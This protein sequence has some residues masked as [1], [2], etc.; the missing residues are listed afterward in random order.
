MSM[1]HQF[2]LYFD[3]YKGFSRFESGSS[4]SQRFNT[5]EVITVGN[6]EEDKEQKHFCR[7]F[8]RLVSR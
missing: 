3:L 8:A 5:I 6:Q 7:I 1:S 4:G 2:K